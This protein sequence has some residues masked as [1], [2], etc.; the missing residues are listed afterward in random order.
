[1]AK[2]LIENTREHDITLSALVKTV[3]VQATVPGARQNPDNRNELIHGV[4][5]VDGELLDLAKKNSPVVQHYFDEGWLKPA[6]KKA[7]ADQ[8]KLES[9]E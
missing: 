3:T 2:V 7:I 5:E 8:A 9:K 1:M 6:T 4:A